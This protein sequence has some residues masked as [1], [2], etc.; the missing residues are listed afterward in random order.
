V[1]FSFVNQ[2][3]LDFNLNDLKL[4]AVAKDILKKYKKE[5][6]FLIGIEHGSAYALYYSTKF[7]K[8]C[9]GIICFPLRNYD[10]EPLDRRIHKFKDNKGWEKHVTK[11]YDVDNYFINI[12]NERLQ[13]LIKLQNNK[14]EGLIL[15]LTSELELR[16][17]YKKIEK[18][19][20]KI[21]VPTIIYERF[22]YNKSATLKRNYENSAIADMKKIASEDDAIVYV[23]VT[24]MSKISKIDKMIEKNRNNENL[25]FHYLPHQD[26]DFFDYGIYIVNSVKSFYYSHKKI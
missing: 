4:K 12:N 26:N 13:E 15:L 1:K 9:S 10:K 17:Q 3:K 19:F 11:K 20:R 6:I 16:K 21:N 22:D 5:K 8:Y 14:E 23:A 2:N 24:A 18:T 7:K 25:L